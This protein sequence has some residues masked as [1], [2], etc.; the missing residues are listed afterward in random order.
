MDEGIQKFKAG[1]S[2]MYLKSGKKDSPLETAKRNNGI[3]GFK[4]GG[5]CSCGQ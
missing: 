2:V 1:G 5:K 4:K 3:P